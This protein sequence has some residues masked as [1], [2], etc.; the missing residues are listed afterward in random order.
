MVT[1]LP[2]YKL[3]RWLAQHQ[4]TLAYLQRLNK[5]LTHRMTHVLLSVSAL[6]T[7]LL[8]PEAV[9]AAASVGAQLNRCSQPSNSYWAEPNG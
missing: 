5:Q 6:W 3:L 1:P 2:P 9:Q 7:Q 4:Q 8:N